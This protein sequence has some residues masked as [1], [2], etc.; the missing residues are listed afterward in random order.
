MQSPQSACSVVIPCP[1]VHLNP[2]ILFQTLPPQI[3][4]E[5]VWGRLWASF[6]FPNLAALRTSA[7]DPTA[8]W[9]LMLQRSLESTYKGGP[10]P[11]L[12]WLNCGRFVCTERVRS[13]SVPFLRG[14]AL[15]KL[16]PQG[17]VGRLLSPGSGPGPC[18]M[19]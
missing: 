13:K 9:P 18:N 3:L 6:S 1:P 10:H 14:K 4:I 15:G 19:Y 11:N 8:T 16:H 7:T 17:G 12:I 5:L 2:P